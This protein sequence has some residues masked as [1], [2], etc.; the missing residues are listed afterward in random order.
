MQYVLVLG[1]L[2]LQN[3][4]NIEV[5][6]Y[7]LNESHNLLE[8]MSMQQFCP[9]CPQ[10]L[11]PTNSSMIVHQVR[12]MQTREM[13]QQPTLLYSWTLATVSHRILEILMP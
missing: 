2:T 5:H 9:L 6:C 4:N 11:D 3:C 12:T 13:P 1:V 7:C 8:G 10:Q